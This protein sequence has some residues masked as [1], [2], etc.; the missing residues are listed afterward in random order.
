MDTPLRSS[1]VPASRTKRRHVDV[2]SPE[3]QDELTKLMGQSSAH[4]VPPYV[5]IILE[6][7]MDTRE[8]ME[9]IKKWCV[10]V[11]EENSKLK[12]ENSNLR[13]II[14]EKESQLKSQSHPFSSQSS[15]DP[16][17]V[18]HELERQRSIVISGIPESNSSA[19]IERSYYDLQCVNS[20]LNHLDVE[21]IPC[22]VYRMGRYNATRGR[23]VKVVLPT[24]K[25]QQLAVKRASRLRSFSHKGVYL[26][27]SLTKEE[28]DRMRDARLAKR[29]SNQPPPAVASPTHPPLNPSLL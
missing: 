29:N 15:V 24:T 3:K 8:Q 2:P 10:K 22:S 7:L 12:V 28:R 27:P 17:F 16:F 14:E 4:E 23:L 11:S 25:F 26:R 9:T 19:P 13:K 20:I 6:A 21:C 1:S 18:Q 5:K